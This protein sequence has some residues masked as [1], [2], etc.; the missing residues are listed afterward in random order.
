MDYSKLDW[1]WSMFDSS[2]K[3]CYIILFSRKSAIESM[4]RDQNLS[5]N[6]AIVYRSKLR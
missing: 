6:G 1:E 2:K 4:N 3:R 5:D